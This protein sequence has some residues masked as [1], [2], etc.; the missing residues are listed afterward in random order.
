MNTKAL[1]ALLILLFGPGVFAQPKA[2]LF[3]E[4]QYR[5]NIQQWE[6]FDNIDDRVVYFSP[7]TIDLTIDVFYHLSIVSTTFLPNHGVVYLCKDEKHQNVTVTLIGDERMFVY[8]N[9]KRFLINFK[10][11]NRAPETNAFANAED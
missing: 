3:N 8:A 4:I 2:L 11:A 7:E 1:L 6:S 5:N 10:T 9:N